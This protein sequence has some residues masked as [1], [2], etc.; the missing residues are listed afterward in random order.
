V[1]REGTV[2]AQK[3]AEER[4]VGDEEANRWLRRPQREPYE[5]TG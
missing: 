4:F 1:T 5:I 2:I 3:A